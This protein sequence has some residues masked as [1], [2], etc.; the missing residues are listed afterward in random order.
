MDGA[1][2]THGPVGS[3]RHIWTF[4]AAVYEQNNPYIP[5]YNCACTNTSC[6]WPFEIPS[7]IGKNYF[8]D[9]GN[10][11]PGYS[12]TD[13]YSDDP[14]WDGQGCGPSS[15]CCELNRPPWFCVQL[16]EVTREDLELRICSDQISSDEDVLVSYVNMYV[17]T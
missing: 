17:G 15:T 12:L 7:F 9:T 14:L 2:L 10:S 13:I 4:A 8:C 5:R 16:D 3:R 6:N 11:G 1:S